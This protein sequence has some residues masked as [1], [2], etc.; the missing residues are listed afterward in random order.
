MGE[1]SL[2]DCG[3]QDVT[4]AHLQAGL[5]RFGP[6]LEVVHLEHVMKTQK[7]GTAWLGMA[8]NA[9]EITA[10]FFLHNLFCRLP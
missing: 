1:S 8:K 10:Y 9:S 2:V 3:R 7:I 6:T 4:T 5:A